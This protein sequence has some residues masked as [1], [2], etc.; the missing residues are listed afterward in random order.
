MNAIPTAPTRDLVKM[1]YEQPI[2]SQL[3]HQ[4][5]KSSVHHL[6]QKF[7]SHLKDV[8]KWKLVG[9]THLDDEDVGSWYYADPEGTFW[10]GQAGWEQWRGFCYEREWHMSRA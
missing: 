8:E 7:L 5:F 4:V 2:Q 6:R 1:A 9:L 10:I 3:P